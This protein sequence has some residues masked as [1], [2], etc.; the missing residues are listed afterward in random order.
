MKLDLE[1]KSVLVTG[2][3][4]GIGR[5]IAEGFL[6]EGARTVV[7]G[8]RRQELNDTMAD[9][10][11]EFGKDK[12]FGFNGDLSSERILE[13]AKRFITNNIG[14]LDHLICNIG[15]GRSVPPLQESADEFERMIDINL[16]TA[17]KAVNILSPL[18]LKDVKQSH[19][20]SK[21]IIFVGSICGVQAMGCPSGYSAAKSGIISYA[22]NIARPLGKMGIRVNVLSPGNIIFDDSTWDLK[23]QNDPDQ[24]T[25]M[26]EAHVAL[27]R[28]G[29]P[30]EIADVAVFMA[31][32]RSS[33][34]TG[35]NWIVDGGQTT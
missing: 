13:A 25:A 31:S 10:S 16:I 26:L 22:K 29:S 20:A 1:N 18:M 8:R 19:K 12:A 5:A 17:V 32:S 2:S 34:V 7:T 11:S 33:F 9:F 15:S 27:N 21:S 28:L 24:V 3:S 35:A 30:E 14:Y 6:K 4:C 23:R